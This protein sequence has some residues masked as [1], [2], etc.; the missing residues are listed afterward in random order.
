M[1]EADVGNRDMA[2]FGTHE[3]AVKGITGGSVTVSMGDFPLYYVD[4]YNPGDK[5][6]YNG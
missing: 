5:P 1:N 4:E 6:N 3:Y 2:R